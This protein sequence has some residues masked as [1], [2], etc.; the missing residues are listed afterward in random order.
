MFEENL[1]ES[2]ESL[3]FNNYENNIDNKEIKSCENKN[4]EQNDI[5]SRDNDLFSLEDDENDGAGDFESAADDSSGGSDE[6]GGADDGSSDFDDSGDSA[7]FDD[8][9]DSDMSFDDS[10]DGDSGD[11]TSDSGDNGG[12]DALDNNKGSSLN[13]F[14]QINQ[15]TYHLDR[16][17]ELL[18]SIRHS[19]DLYNVNYA[20]WS[21]VD[22]L[23]ELGTIVANEQK[24][25]VMQQN[26]E[27]LIKLGLY[28]EQYDIIVQNISRKISKLNSNNKN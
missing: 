22:Q 2:Y 5:I 25:F 17:N 14:T 23:K 1:K 28:Y 19:I 9:G 27:N 4:I 7:G 20:D 12:L 8:S 11:S 16:L 26:P 21:E 13:P 6:F 10:G 15:K 24:S 3:F 18:N